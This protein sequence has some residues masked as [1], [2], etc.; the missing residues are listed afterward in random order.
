MDLNLLITGSDLLIPGSYSQ[1]INGSEL[2]HHG[3][4]P[5][6]SWDMTPSAYHGIYLC[7]LRNLTLLFRGSEPALHGT[8]AC[9]ARDLIP[10]IYLNQENVALPLI[11]HQYLT[12]MYFVQICSLISYFILQGM[13]YTDDELC[14][15]Q[16]GF[17]YIFRP[18]PY[19]WVNMWIDLFFSRYPG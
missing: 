12:L 1:L 13:S 16:H 14:E 19:S 4:W 5:W 7:S 15:L 18:F 2:T 8:W 17:G 11:L 6:S 3:I 10:L 9:S